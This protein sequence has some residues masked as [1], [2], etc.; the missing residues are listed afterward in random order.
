MF[1]RTKIN[2]SLMLCTEIFVRSGFVKFELGFKTISVLKLLRE[3]GQ[4]ISDE[5][6]PSK[7]VTN[8]DV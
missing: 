7:D 3:N 1:G 5:R 8:F 2:V 4:A 6:D